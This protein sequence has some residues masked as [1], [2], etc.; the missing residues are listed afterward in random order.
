MTSRSRRAG[1]RG[2]RTN[3]RP[4]ASS[5]R[6]WA[7]ALRGRRVEVVAFTVLAYVPFLFS[8][9]G[10]VS[11][12]T[13]AYLYLDPGRLLARAPYLWDAHVGAGT[14][15]HQNIGYLFP[16]GPYYWL[17]G[18]LDVPSWVA[19]RLWLGSISLAAALGA[20]WLLSMLGTRRAGVIAGAAVFMLTPYQLAFTA[21]LSVLLLSW[22][23][24]PW[25][26]GLTIRAA[27]RGGWRDPILFAFV[28]LVVGGTNA[29]TL[30]LVGLGPVLWLVV[31]VVA[32]QVDARAALRAA[33]RIAVP[34]V[35]LSM[36]WV[37]GLTI[38]GSRGLPILQLS[39]TVR[40]TSASS[41]PTDLLRGIGNWFFYGGD[42]LGPWI[43]QSRAY[44]DWRWLVA[45]TFAVPILALGAAAVVRWRHRA[46]FG[47]L[48]VVGTVIGVGPWPY[49]DPSPLGE[50]FSGFASDSSV[51][52]AF[53]NTA[54][55]VPLIVLGM[56][57]LLAAAV[58]ALEPRRLRVGAGVAVVGLVVLNFAPVWQ[59]GY[60]SE[61]LV[62]PEHVPR[63]WERAAVALER[64]GATSR[65]LEIP[66]SDF[67][68]YRWGNT[69][70]PITPGLVDRPWMGRESIPTGSAG[71]V[72]LL[73]ALDRRIQEGTF[74]PVTLAP[75]ARLLAA[76]TILV[77]S[78]LEYERYETPRPRL[79]WSILTDPL[80]PGVRAPTSFG[81]SRPN[82]A[83]PARPLL[84]ELEL[85]TPTDAPWPPAVA[86][87]PVVDAVPI[88]HVAPA[89]GPVLF[90]GD[91]EGLVDAAEAR[92]LDGTELI[93]TSAS[94]TGT[95]LRAALRADAALLVTDS[96]RR[97]ARRWTALR[98]VTGPTE[99][100]G[101][102]ALATDYDDHR[103]PAVPEGGDRARTVVEQRGGRVDATSSGDRGRYTP[104]NRPVHAFDGDPRTAWRVAGGG[105]P[106]GERLVLEL[107]RPVWADHARLVQPQDGSQDRWVT[108]V[109]VTID[110]GPPL[111]VDLGEA[112]RTPDGQ[113]V[114]FPEHRVRRL[115]IEI[116]DTNLGAAVDTR[117][118]AGVGFAEVLLADVRVAEIVR[119]PV[120]LLAR[121]GVDSTGHPLALVLSRL[122][123]DPSR[124][125]RQDEELAIARRFV[126]P[127]A[128]TF[129][130]A[131]TARVAPNARDDVID[132]VLGT[133]AVGATFGA[134]SHLAGD[135]EA[136]A[137]R[138]FDHDPATA[139]TAR[140]GSQEGQWVEVRSA[141]SVTVD[142]VDLAIVADGRHS[143]PTTFRLEADGVPVRT[144]VVPPIADGGNIGTVAEVSV[145]FEAVTATTLR[146]VV[147]TTRPVSTV[148]DRTGAPIALPV[149]IAETGLAGVSNPARVDQ[150]PGEC[151]DDLVSIDGRPLSVRFRGDVDA[152][153]SGLAL[154][155]CTGPLDLRRGSHRVRAVAGLD[156]GIDVDQLIFR[157]RPGRSRPGRS[158]APTSP[159]TSGEPEADALLVEPESAAPA[160]VKVLDSGPASFDL[161]IRSDGRPFWLV[162]G[163]SQSAGWEATTGSGRSLGSSSLVDSYANGWLVRPGRAGS[164]DVELRWA[165]QR[166]V[167][168]GIGV[169]ALAILACLGVLFATRRRPADARAVADAPSLASPWSMLGPTP[170][171]RTVLVTALGLGVVSGLV[172]RPWIGAL[173]GIATLVA[174]RVACGRL[175]L[176]AGAPLALAVAKA[177][178]APELGWLAVLL[179]LAD[180]GLARG[181]ARAGEAQHALG[182]DVLVDLGGTARDR[183]G[184]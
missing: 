159:D 106:A 8:S 97:R 73:A 3:A 170:P 181:S 114:E 172:S 18:Q 94:L 6:R 55:V 117:G 179:L 65:I 127:D 69:V 36:W 146:L 20:M 119:L 29:S 177:F 26:V 21:R 61:R 28:V 138:A 38:Q 180:L 126:L 79:L 174:A 108:R 1:P 163:Q 25:L 183:V 142:R 34:T 32:R 167:W 155:A 100:A 84:D 134:S 50:I 53:R 35:G 22:A 72:D 158:A 169:S 9:P 166:M 81:P 57:G 112:S 88:V 83:G 176:S 47:L 15:P 139:W 40:T 133:T 103:L 95:E 2:D 132:S 91:G 59:H 136:R 11:A 60:L 4:A 148:D 98:D 31:A 149:A 152:A 44:S 101:Q 13:K 165:P 124:R 102:H 46:Y 120:D 164:I 71:A 41:L 105:D 137:S 178:D 89:L 17:M 70:D 175:L 107:E 75:V 171:V 109:R 143:V 54:R 39:E 156:T 154:E 115:E 153:R 184:P 92:L 113:S 118:S 129:A 140:V 161:R 122:R 64:D 85:A 87:F 49:D 74:D 93:R 78:D 66:G 99:R 90:A 14:V 33:V 43:D 63:Y 82:V 130:L 51:G 141:T 30:I 150:V 104:E 147:E 23:A 121:A 160:A 162:L 12:D 110:G 68:A 125:D 151:R 131:G 37:V 52:L 145:P 76:G 123:G 135:A 27:R 42:R 96:N 58:S 24:L 77:R 7:G 173:V 48:I 5:P 128:R 144:L 45:T 16:M 80:P 168:W 67:A 62:A 182:D 56:A 157:S 116:L 111:V 86:L 19:Q 10:K